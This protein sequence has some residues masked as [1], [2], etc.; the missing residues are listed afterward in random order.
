MSDLSRTSSPSLPLW[1][2]R[3]DYYRVALRDV[4]VEMQIGI[5]EWER[6][7]TQRVV[8]NVDLFA[9]QGAH[10]G[11]DISS[12]INYDPIHEF[13]ISQWPSRPHTDLLETLAEE[14]IA[15]CFQDERV[16]AARVSLQKPDV[17]AD[18]GAAEVEFYRVRAS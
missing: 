9:H 18:A 12:C 15:V 10:T 13:I 3:C 2:S 7:A 17:Y 5:A 1:D 8:V 6:G 16:E 14:L 11:S 4:V